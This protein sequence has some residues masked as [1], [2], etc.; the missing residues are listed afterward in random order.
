MKFKKTTHTA[1]DTYKYPESSIFQENDFP[2]RDLAN[3]FFPPLISFVNTFG[4]RR[5]PSIIQ[6]I[7]KSFTEFHKRCDNLYTMI[8]DFFK[9]YNYKSVEDFFEKEIPREH[10]IDVVVFFYYMCF[11]VNIYYIKLNNFLKKL[12]KLKKKKKPI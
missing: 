8:N 10:F 11:R 9:K 5:V 3:E 2:W 6:D 12:L 4:K 7:A 1:K